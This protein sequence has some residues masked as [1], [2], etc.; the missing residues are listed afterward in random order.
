MKKILIPMFALGAMF[1][2][3]PAMANEAED[4]FNSKGCTACHSVDNKIVGPAYQDVAEKYADEDDAVDQL[5]NSIKEGS[6]GTWGQVPMP[7]NNVTEDE[8]KVLAEWVLDQ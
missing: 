2:I 4:L 1:A 7:P 3:Q 6:S 5:A 8:A